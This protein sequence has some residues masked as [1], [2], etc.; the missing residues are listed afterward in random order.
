[1]ESAKTLTLRDAIAADAAHLRAWDEKTHVKAAV[2]ND[3]LTSFNADWE[4]EILH[5]C[6]DALFLIAEVNGVPI[7][8]LQINDP[9]TEKT[10][11]WGAV[12]PNMRAIDIWIGEEDYL[13]QG[14]G[15]EMMNHAIQRCFSNPLVVAIL[16]DPL[17]SNTASHRF[18]QR[19]GFE[20]VERRQFDETSDCFVFKLYRENWNTTIHKS[21]AYAGD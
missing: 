3:G 1:M 13:G 20:F 8:A 2:S 11:Y 19:L 14:Y 16:I 15:T 12:A 21:K 17:A 6:M 7:G 10:H 18:Y 9:A 4:D 5:P